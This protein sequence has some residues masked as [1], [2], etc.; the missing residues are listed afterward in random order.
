M[1]RQKGGKGGSTRYALKCVSKRHAI[2]HQQAEALVVERSIMAEL[3]HPFVYKFIRSYSGPSYVYFL[4]ELVTGGELID[5]LD[6][7]GCLKRP[8][9]QFYLGSIALALEFL[10]ERRIAYLDLKGENCLIDQHGYLKMIDF[11]IAERVK[12][13]RL[14]VVKGTPLFMAPEVIL[15]KGYTT[16]ADLWSLGVCLY[17]FMVGR[18]PFADDNASKAE[19][20]RAI[21]KSPLAFPK[22]VPLDSD[23]KNL[24]QGL[25]SRDPYQRPGAG[26][27]GYASLMEHAWFEG[28][29]WDGLLARQLTPPFEPQGET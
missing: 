27:E 19:V 22:K 5:V 6:V 24:L 20:F 7:L 28:F 3:D 10:H 16:T 1:V 29:S 11:G 9:A 14:H 13:G 26:A 18:F 12:N 21:L 15:G 25:L 2:E 8:Q 23:T 17:D 4:T